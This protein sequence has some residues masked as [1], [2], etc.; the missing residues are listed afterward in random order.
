[1]GLAGLGLW[2]RA[3]EISRA[4]IDVLIC[5]AVTR[6]LMDALAASGIR[7]VPWV[8]GEVNEI[9]DAFGSGELAEGRFSMPGCG[10]Q[11]CRRRRRSGSDR[12]GR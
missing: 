3:A 2:S 5:G 9:L 7:V 12:R 4:G 1:V 11:R 8:S 6:P 10:R